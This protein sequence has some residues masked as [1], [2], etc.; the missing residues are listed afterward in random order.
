MQLSCVYFR[1]LRRNVAQRNKSVKFAPNT[2]LNSCNAAR[3]RVSVHWQIMDG[4]SLSLSAHEGESP[5]PQTT[6]GPSQSGS[7]PTTWFTDWNPT[8][9]QL[10]LTWMP[11][12]RHDLQQTVA[13]ALAG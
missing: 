6:G 12:E 3:H 5:E 11:L 1:Q 8:G 2:R 7:F 9:T 10:Q 13:P 4:L